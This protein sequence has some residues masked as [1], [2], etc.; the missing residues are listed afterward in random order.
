MNRRWVFGAL[1]ATG[2]VCVGTW[3]W[4]DLT[5]SKHDF[6]NAEWADGDRCG[7]CHGPA[8]SVPTSA[9]LWDPNADLSR[10]F[11]PGRGSNKPTPGAGTT[12][13]LRCHDGT[14]ASDA[15]GGVQPERDRFAN[16][17]NPGLYSAGMERADHPVGVR[18][19]AMDRSF[20]PRSFV[21]SEGVVLLPA[22]RVEC[23]SCHDPHNADDTGQMLVKS[24]AR[25]A[26]C[27]TCHKK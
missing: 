3:A 2:L 17:R 14:I 1:L 22:G 18:Y 27:L 15:V 25:S 21:E 12:V 20:R 5:G 19:P 23:T 4:A 11:G 8:S 7:A 26:L 24:N 13:C 9:P 16:K 10:R 6:S